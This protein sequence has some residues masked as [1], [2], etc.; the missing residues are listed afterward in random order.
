MLEIIKNNKEEII[1]GFI[2]IFF[3]LA[4]S[5]YRVE[6]DGWCY[7]AF[8]E[9]ILHIPNPESLLKGYSSQGFQQDGCAYLNIP[10]YLLAYAI[11]ALFHRQWNFNG[12]TLRQI[13]I[14]LA[15]IFYMLLSIVLV[16]KILKRMNFKY[17]ISPV[18]SILFSTTAFAAAVVIPSWNHTADIFVGTL[19]IYL[20]FVGENRPVALF[21][22][23][24]LYV[25]SI[26]VRYFNFILLIPVLIYYVN[27]KEY[28]KIKYLIMGV[29]SF[30]WVIPLIFYTYN[31]SIWNISPFI[32][33]AGNTTKI[34]PGGIPMF[35]IFFLKYL[36]HPLHGL[37]VWSPVT[38]LS[39]IGL[40]VFPKKK[41]KL[42]Y[43]FLAV[44][45]LFLILYGYINCWYAGWSFS[46]RYLVNLFPIYIIGVAAFLEK[47]G[48][49]MIFLVLITTFYSI[50]L[51]LNWHLCI[52]NPE[53]GTPVDII[54]AWIKGESDT[55]YDK[56]VDIVTILKRLYEMC[57]YKYLIKI[58]L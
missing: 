3:A 14:N 58:F 6:G 10:F 4:F 30:I 55:S 36:L 23:G 45:A 54:K 47:Y 48:R 57:R 7:Y 41:E 32:K 11:E 26:L 17:I 25:I 24:V 22:A 37:F 16:I 39:V 8:L 46:N 9:N 49:K 50:I 34:L 52:M 13:S 29:I 53:F 44:W 35:P 5:I 31:G 51:F 12:I 56:K 20:L 2:F 21:W 43:V 33:A 18:L 38:I 27:L 28:K 40:F 1:V 15:S 19:F 42:G